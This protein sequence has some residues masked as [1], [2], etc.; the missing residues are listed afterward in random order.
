MIERSQSLI[1]VEQKT[2]L[3]VK[4]A[5]QLRKDSDLMRLSVQGSLLAEIDGSEVWKSEIEAK[6]AL[7][8]YDSALTLAQSNV[9]KEDRLHLLSIIAKTQR[10]QGLRMPSRKLCKEVQ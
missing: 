8:D 4:A 6:M 2:E 3:G 5:R 9:L 7:N 10:E 1:P